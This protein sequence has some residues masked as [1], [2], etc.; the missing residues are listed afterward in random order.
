MKSSVPKQSNTNL[1]FLEFP[2]DGV[3]RDMGPVWAKVDMIRL[4][5]VERILYLDSDVLVH[6]DLKRLWDTCKER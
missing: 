2:E 6:A 4:L 5:L 1:M 3:A